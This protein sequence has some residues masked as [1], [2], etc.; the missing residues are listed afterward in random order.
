M[1]AVNPGN[2]DL[3]SAYERERGIHRGEA[4]AR[5]D[6]MADHKVRVAD[7]AAAKREE[8]TQTRQDR[9]LRR[10]VA[11]GANP[12]SP[13]TQAMHPEAVARMKAKTDKPAAPVNPLD[14]G[15]PNTPEGAAAGAEIIADQAVNS[16][17]LSGWGVT[18]DTR[19]TEPLHAG[20]QDMRAKG[21]TPSD[22]NLREIHRHT[23]ALRKQKTNQHDPFHSP[24]Y[25]PTY[26]LNRFGSLYEELSSLPEE[27]STQDLRKWWSKVEATQYTS[28]PS[29]GAPTYP[30][31]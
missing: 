20:I 4:D 13:K 9:A 15:A 29:T 31:Y 6:W 23:L 17:L 26:D 28:A 22:E 27:V 11:A 10:A 21:L 8:R 3:E 1:L 18:A 5:R 12:L 24:W 30:G 14:P 16:Q 2:A 19:D 7:R 25:A